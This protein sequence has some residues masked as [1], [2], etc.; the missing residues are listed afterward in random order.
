MET[1][2]L[3]CY[4]FAFPA[5]VVLFGILT[6]RGEPTRY[7]IIQQTNDL[8]ESSYEL[9]FKYGSLM[10]TY[11]WCLEGVFDTEQEAQ[12]FIA[13]RNVNRKVIQEGNLVPGD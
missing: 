4:F 8:G 12:E 9:W 6:Y 5:L 11:P 10:K 13:K 2:E 3:L 7:K 1:L